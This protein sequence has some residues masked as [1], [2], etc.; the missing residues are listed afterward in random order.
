MSTDVDRLSG[1]RAVAWHVR[2]AGALRRLARS[3]IPGALALVV[4][5]QA[6]FS[7]PAAQVVRAE[8]GST[9]QPSA[10]TSLLTLT[11]QARAVAGLRALKKDTSLAGVA[12][13]RSLDMLNNDYFAHE[14]PPSG[15]MVFSELDRKKICYKLAGENIGWNTYPAA[16]AVAAIQTSFMNSPGHRSNILGKAWDAAGIGAYLAPS[17]KWMFTVLFSQ[18][19]KKK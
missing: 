1:G 12:D 9:M 19:C 15:R 3:L 18:R 6:V 5:L 14:I 17:G 13:W 8:G 4:A 2:P 11:N 10:E 7:G 16:E